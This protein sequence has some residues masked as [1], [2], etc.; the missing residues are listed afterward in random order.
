MDLSQPSTCEQSLTR[1]NTAM[2]M[3][4][5]VVMVARGRRTNGRLTTA[6]DT[7]GSHWQ[8][9][10]FS[11][12]RRCSEVRRKKTKCNQTGTSNVT[13]LQSAICRQHARVIHS[14]LFQGKESVRVES[15]KTACPEQNV[16][17][18]L[19]SQKGVYS[20]LQPSECRR[21][22]SCHVSILRSS[23]SGTVCTKTQ[24]LFTHAF[25][26]CA[27]RVGGGWWQGN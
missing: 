26:T 15:Q 16:R 2:I 10:S 9:D 23:N 27:N 12:N 4:T 20:K 24:V 6:S 14:Q 5:A 7:A 22:F 21:Q 18:H 19:Q 8:P 1:L 13:F 11:G 25:I 17:C 3:M